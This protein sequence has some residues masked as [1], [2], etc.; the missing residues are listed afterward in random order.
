VDGIAADLTTRDGAEK[1]F[2]RAKDLDIVINNLGIFEARPFLDID[3]AEW[4]RFFEAKVRSGVPVTRPYL[5][6]MLEK[7]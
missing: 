3:N 7:K 2:A 5:S 4:V 6:G 1:L